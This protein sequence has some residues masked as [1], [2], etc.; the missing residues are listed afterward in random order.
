MKRRSHKIWALIAAV[1][2]AHNLT[3]E[4]GDTLSEAVDHWLERRP[5]LTRMII[6]T[7]AA[8]LANE[9]TVDP[10]GIGFGA[11]RRLTRRPRVVVDPN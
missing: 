8:H 2:I 4:D 7:L 9:L 11:A 6:T 5:W 10:I 3:A 1:V